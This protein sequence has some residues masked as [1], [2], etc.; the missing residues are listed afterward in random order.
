MNADPRPIEILIVDDEPSI[1]LLLKRWIQRS[2]TAKVREARDGLQALEQISGGGIEMMIADINMPV[3]DGIDM[4]RALQAE[5]ARKSMEVLVASQVANE[6]KVRQAIALGVSDYLLK[7]LQYEWVIQR[8]TRAAERI[9]QRRRPVSEPPA[10][11]RTRVLVA[12]AD[13]NYCAFADSALSADFSVQ[14]ARTPAMTLVKALRARPDVLLLNPRMPGLDAELLLGALSRQHGGARPRVYELAAKDALPSAAGVA[15]VIPQTFVPEALVS[16]VTALLR[17][18]DVPDHGALAWAAAL[19]SEMRTA[20]FQALGMLTGIEPEPVEGGPEDAASAVYGWI[21]VNASSPELS[22]RLGLES[23]PDLPGRLTA[24]MLGE[25]PGPDD[26]SQ[27]SLDAIQ[28]ILNILAGRLQ[29]S[30]LERK[31]EVTIGQPQTS[32]EPPPPRKPQF[33][34][35]EWYRWNGCEPFRLCLEASCSRAQA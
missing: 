4:L 9:Y 14:T 26:A 19:E 24:A 33:E 25:A 30:C 2:L 28:E 32:L 7:P 6:E 17:G 1:R 11:S 5:P 8:L 23:G 12:D 29:S 15:G 31:V 27:P 21:A 20:L 16:Q 34:R 13:P 35:H 10:G 3:L 22:M 18:S